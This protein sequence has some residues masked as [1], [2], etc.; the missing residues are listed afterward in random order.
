VTKF[1]KL[2]YIAGVRSQESGEERKK[3][4]E[5]N[6]PCSLFPVPFQITRSIK[7][8]WLIL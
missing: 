2:K 3:K 1:A 4:K 5:E 7:K 6:P 8:C